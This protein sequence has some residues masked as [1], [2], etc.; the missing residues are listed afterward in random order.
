MSAKQIWEQ[1]HNAD[2]NPVEFDGIKRQAGLNSYKL[3]VKEWVEKTNAIG[4]GATAGR[5]GGTFAHRDIAI[6]Q[7]QTLIARTAKQWEG[8]SE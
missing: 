7:M 2:F 8:G 1:L 3:I 5:Y 6:R 4:L